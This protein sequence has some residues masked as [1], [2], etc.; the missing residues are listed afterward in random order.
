MATITDYSSLKSAIADHLNR[1]DLTSVIPTLIQLSERKFVR[2]RRV[3]K[4]QNAGTYNVSSD[5]QSLPSDFKMLDSLYHDTDS[6]R[7]H[8]QIVSA[9][10]LSEIKR[11]LGSTG[12]PAYAAVFP[13]LTLRFAPSPDQT[14]ETK[15]TYWRTITPLSSSNTTNWLL[16]SHPDIYLYGSL[17]ESAPYL[18]DDERLQVWG[19]MRDGALEELDQYTKNLSYGGGPMHIGWRSFGNNV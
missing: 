6:N 12:V 17:L 1:D 9:T 5:D 7:G 15:L 14:Y 3:R 8:I 18:K 2:D 10:Q 19:A 4:F 11:R 13:D 16:T